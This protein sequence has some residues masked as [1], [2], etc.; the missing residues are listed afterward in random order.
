MSDAGQA[1]HDV[2]IS[3]STKDKPWADAACAVLETRR[4]RCWI[5]PRDILPGTEWGAAIIGGIDACRVMVL[6]FSA[7][8]NDSA[9]VRREV[10]RAIS[11]G[12]TVLPVRVEDVPP[13]GAMEFALSNTH[14]LDAFTPPV[15][16]QMT[17][18][19]DAVRA[20]LATHGGA[21]GAATADAGEARVPTPTVPPD[22][23][24]HSAAR[25]RRWLMPSV[26]AAGALL[27]GA[28]L[29]GNLLTHKTKDGVVS[30]SIDPPV[31]DVSV[32]DGKPA[33]KAAA[34]KFDPAG[35]TV[36]PL[37]EG[38]RVT[39]TGT[40]GGYADQRTDTWD[41][42]VPAGSIGTVVKIA[43]DKKRCRV[44]LD[45]PVGVEVWILRSCLEP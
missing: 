28:V 35:R 14:W 43:N 37:Q 30:P 10:E 32:A 24:L 2:F 11:K 5:A 17:R 18:L 36:S 6:I 13:V 42:R 44:R 33:N 4:V 29:A 1:T 15:E 27:V 21:T 25:S 38:S 45:E 40:T 3:H 7:H 23:R 22:R 26:I 39:V 8:A 20:L 41:L 31:T 19:A 34:P 9:Q 12:M 16:R